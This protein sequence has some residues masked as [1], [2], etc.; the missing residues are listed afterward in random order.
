MIPD[1]ITELFNETEIENIRNRDGWAVG[2]VEL[3]VDGD[4]ERTI[5]DAYIELFNGEGLAGEVGGVRFV[6]VDEGELEE[7]YAFAT[8]RAL[9]RSIQSEGWVVSAW[10]DPADP[11]YG[12]AAP[13]SRR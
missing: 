12:L 1:A 5:E 2:T 3:V 7:S 6:A 8:R 4:V 9:E 11:D 10:T 13:R